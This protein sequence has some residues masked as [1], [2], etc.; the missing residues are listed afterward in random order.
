MRVACLA[1]GRGSNFEA[2]IQAQRRGE[3]AGATVVTLGVNRPGCGAYHR[4]QKLGVPSFLVDHQEFDSK[5]AFEAMLCEHLKASEAELIVLAGFMRI[6]SD[7]F[8]R[9]IRVPVVNLHPAL[10]PAFPGLHGIEEAFRA[11]VRLSGCTTHFVTETVDDGPILMQGLV[12]IFSQDRLD[13]FRDRMHAMEH[14]ILPATV[15]AIARGDLAWS[16]EG[17]V[18]K[19]H[20]KPYLLTAD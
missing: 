17:L 20:F 15:A 7:H 1:S 3:T 4:A 12:P 11:G 6:L 9:E 16:K 19:P 18:S 5:A 14:R 8:L 13:D 10:L 2:L